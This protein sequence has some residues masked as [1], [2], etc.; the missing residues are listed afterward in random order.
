MPEELAKLSYA[1]N[2]SWKSSTGEDRYRRGVYTFFKRT[3]P[4]P[5]LMT[6]DAPDANVACVERTVSN[7]PLQSL[8]LLNNESHLEA[9]Q[10][11]ARRALLS[12]ATTDDERLTLALR[13]C[14]TRPPSAAEVAV[15]KRTLDEGRSYYREHEADAKQFAGDVKIENQ[16]PT[17][18]AAWTATMRVVL[19]L[20]EFL[21]RE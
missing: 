4:H 15:L 14:V 1:N 3:I 20:D 5:S 17:D 7:T 21:T 9:A 18:V 8:T 2:F 16:T 10:R 13:W 12:S 11:M 19:N 6:F